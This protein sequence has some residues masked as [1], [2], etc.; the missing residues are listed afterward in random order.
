M[1]VTSAFRNN[2]AQEIKRFQDMITAKRQQQSRSNVKPPRQ[3]P[4]QDDG[5]EF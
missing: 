3:Q 2:S 5:P 4:R 1:S